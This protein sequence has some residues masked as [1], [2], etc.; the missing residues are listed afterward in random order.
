MQA[1]TE[2]LLGPE[3][4]LTKCERRIMIIVLRSLEAP[5]FWYK[6]LQVGLGLLLTWYKSLAPCAV[7]VKGYI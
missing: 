6:M 4:A 5:N 1:N 3:S 2:T 7:G